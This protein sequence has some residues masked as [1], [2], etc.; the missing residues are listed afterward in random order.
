MPSVSHRE[1]EVI[2]IISTDDE[3]TLILCR[4][5]DVIISHPGGKLIAMAVISPL[6]LSGEVKKHFE[7]CSLCQRVIREEK[8]DLR[9]LMERR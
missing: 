6:R 3:K 8:D 5:C 9:Q 2:E 7:D 1:C 4:K